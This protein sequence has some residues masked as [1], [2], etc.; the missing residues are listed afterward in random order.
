MKLDRY[1][2]LTYIS[3]NSF[4]GLNATIKNSI[5]I[6]EKNIIGSGSNV[7]KSTEPQ[8]I[9]VGNPAKKIKEISDN[10]NI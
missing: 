10:I 1:E 9:Y 7:I 3:K 5:S 6:A 4:I 2:F 8:S